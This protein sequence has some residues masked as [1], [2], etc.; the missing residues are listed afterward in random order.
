MSFLLVLAMVIGLMPGMSLTAK[1]QTT[2]SGNGT[3]SDPYRITSADDWNTL[4][5]SV[6]GGIDYSGKYLKLMD[7][8]TVS[9]M[10]GINNHA[11]GSDPQT[12][13]RSF[14]GTFDGDG[15]TLNL[16]IKD[17]NTHGAAP[18]SATKNATIKNLNVT[19]SVVGGI[20]SAG[21]VG[22]PNGTLT[23]E[24]CTVSAAISDSTHHGGFVGH[25]FNATVNLK[26]CIFDGSLTGGTLGGMIGW[27]GLSADKRP[28]IN[29]DNCLFSGTYTTTG[30]FNPVGYTATDNDRATIT[31]FYTTKAASGTATK[32]IINGTINTTVAQVQVGSGFTYYSTINDAVTAWNSAADGAT[33]KLLTDVTTA[34]T[35][36]VTGTKTLDLNDHV[37]TGNV[38]NGSVIEIRNS[39]TLKLVDSATNKTTRY[40][41][42]TSSGSA[43]ISSTGTDQSFTGGYIT[44]TASGTTSNDFN[45]GYHVGGGVYVAKGSTFN[46]NGGNIFGVNHN[47]NNPEGAGVFVCGTFNMNGGEIVGNYNKNNGGGV[48]TSAGSS[49]QISGGT[50]SHNRTSWGGGITVRG[51]FRMSGG[52][53]SGNT[54]SGGGGGIHVD[55]AGNGSPSVTLTGGSITGNTSS[56][57][58]GGI[59]CYGVSTFNISGSPVINGNKHGDAVENVYLQN[60]KKITVNGALTSDASIGITMQTPGVFTAGGNAA[61]YADCFTSDNEIYIVEKEG[62]E[63][64]LA[65]EPHEHDDIDFTVWTS[66]NSL[67]NTA[68]SYYLKN[69]VTISSTWNVPTGTTNLCLNGHVITRNGKGDAIYLDGSDT[70]N[71]YDC[72]TTKRY[73]KINTS[74]HRGEL[75]DS[76]EGADGSFTGGYITASDGRGISTPATENLKSY[77]NMYGGTVFS[78]KSTCGAGIYSFGHFHMYYGAF[79]GNYDSGQSDTWGGAV[80]N[81]G[82]LVIEGG[83]IRHNYDFRGGGVFQ[84]MWKNSTGTIKGGRIVDNIATNNGGGVYLNYNSPTKPKFIICGNPEISG[85]KVGDSENNVYIPDNT[86]QYVSVGGELSNATPIGISMKTPGVFTNSTDVAFNDA[87]KFTSDNE[88]YV[89]IK[90]G[91]NQLELISANTVA[92]VTSGE[93]TTYYDTLKEAISNAPNGS[94]VTLLKDVTETQTAYMN[95]NGTYGGDGNVIDGKTITI[96]SNGIGDER[97]TVTGSRFDVRNDGN[98]TFKNIII[99][100]GVTSS[101]NKV[102]GTTNSWSHYLMAA[103]HGSTLT[104]D[105][106]TLVKNYY[107]SAHGVINAGGGRYGVYNASNNGSTINIKEGSVFQNLGANYGVFRADYKSTINMSGG[108]VTNCTSYQ[109]EGVLAYVAQGSTFNMSGGEISNCSPEGVAPGVVFLHSSQNNGHNTFTMTGGTIE[110]NTAKLGGAVYSDNVDNVITIGGSAAIAS[111]NTGTQIDNGQTGSSNIYLAAGQTMTIDSTHLGGTSNIGVYTKTAPTESADVK[112]A[113]GASK[114]DIQYIHSDLTGNAGTIFCDGEKDWMYY[115]DTLYEITNTHHT[116]AAGT[117]WLTVTASIKAKAVTYNANG[118]SGGN[119]PTDNT[120]YNIGDTVT[121]LGNAG[122]LTRDGY[123]FD[124]WNTKADGSGTTYAAN[125]AFTITEDTTLYAQW[126]KDYAYLDAVWNAT[127]K[128]VDYPEKSIGADKVTV[129][130]ATTTKWNS[131][132][133]AVTENVTISGR[134]TVNGDVKLIL[135]NGAT[136]TATNGISVD[137]GKKFTV[138]GQTNDTNL[139]GILNSRTQT[140]TGVA[141][142]GIGGSGKGKI[143]GVITINGGKVSASGS[144]EAGGAGIGGGFNAS[145]G[146]TVINGGVVTVPTRKSVAGIG[147]GRHGSG[148]NITI[149]G[150]TVNAGGYAGAAIGGAYQGS[151]G[152]ITINGGTVTATDGTRGAAIGSGEKKNSSTNAGTIRINGGKVIAR[153]TA[154]SGSGGAGIGG[155]Y[156][157]PGGTI[158]I[159]GGEVTAT[160]V[161]G[162]GIGGGPGANGG[163]VTI[164]G[165]TVTAYGSSGGVGIGKGKSGKN[166]GSLTIANDH[167]C[168][169][170]D[171]E[172]AAGAC[173]NYQSHRK[174][175]VKIWQHIHSEITYGIEGNVL[176]AACT[177]DTDNCNLVDGKLTLTL[178]APNKLYDAKVYDK[179]KTAWTSVNHNEWEEFSILTGTTSKS[180]GSIEYY[181]GETK[182]GGAPTEEGTYIAKLPIVLNSKNEYLEQEFMIIKPEAIFVTVPEVKELTY[183][184]TGQELITAGVGRDGTIQYSLDDQNYSD[185]IPAATNAGDYTVWVYVKGDDLHNDSPKVSFDVTIKKKPA[186]ILTDGQ[187]PTANTAVPEGDDPDK[188]TPLLNPP[189]EAAPDGYKIVYAIGKD[190][191]NVPETGWSEDIPEGKDGTYYIW[192]KAVKDDNHEETKP[193]N[194]KVTR[195]DYNVTLSPSTPTVGEPVTVAVTPKDD[196]VVY[197]W[198]TG[199]DSGE[200]TLIAGETGNTYTPTDADKGRTLKV[201]AKLGDKVIGEDIAD[202]PVAETASETDKQIVEGEI[203]ESDGTTKVVNAK[204]TLKRGNTVVAT[205]NTDDNGKYSFS[206]ES[207][208][209]NVVSEYNGVTKTEL[210]EITSSQDFDLTMPEKNTN[211]VLVVGNDAPDIMVGGL[212]VEAETVRA[213]QNG[214]P[215]TVTVTMTVEKKE[216]STETSENINA[217]KQQASDKTLEFFETKLVKVVDNTT[218]NAVTETDNVLTIVVPYDFTGKDNVTVYRSYGETTEALSDKMPGTDGTFQID[219][220]AKTI[221]I[222]TSRLATYAIGYNA[223]NKE[224][225]ETFN[226]EK[227]EQKTAADNLIKEDDSDES[228]DL[229]EAA[230]K[231]I[232]ELPYDYDK[233]LDK[234]KEALDEIINKLEKDL[235]K[236]RVL[237]KL[238]DTPADVKIDQGEPVINVDT[239]KIPEE[240]VEVVEEIAKKTTADIEDAVIKQAQEIVNKSDDVEDSDKNIVIIPSLE[241]DAK[242]YVLSEDDAKLTLDIEAVYKSYETTDDINNAADTMS[243]AASDDEADREKVREIGKGTIDTKGTPVNIRIELPEE[244]AQSIGAT[245]DSTNDAPETAYVKHSSNGINYEYNAKIYYD[246]DG[247]VA[248]FVDPNGLGTFTLSGNSES[249]VSTGGNN[250]TDLQSAIDDTEDGAVIKL[251]NDENVSATINEEKTIT[252]DKDDH[253]G[254][255]DITVPP[256]LILTK[257]DNEDG[258]TTYKAVTKYTVTFNANGGTGTMAVQEIGGKAALNANTFTREGFVFDGWNTKADGKGT[259]YADKADITPTA[260]M[261]LYAQWKENPK[262]EDKKEDDK[263][264]DDKKAD[265]PKTDDKKADE[266]KIDETLEASKKNAEDKINNVV[267]EVNKIVDSLTN[268]TAEKKEELKKQNDTTIA[269][270]KNAVDS[271]IYVEAVEAAYQKAIEATKATLKDAIKTEVESQIVAAKKTIDN[272]KGLTNNQKKALKTEVDKEAK[273]VID[274]L[275]ST[276][277]KIVDNAAKGTTLDAA[278]TKENT[279][280]V[281]KLMNKTA[282]IAKE[283]KSDAQVEVAANKYATPE[284]LRKNTLSIN[285]KLKVEQVGKKIIIEWGK[286]KDADGY[287]VFVQYCGKDFSKKASK[288]IKKNSTTKLSVTKINGKKLN[289]KKNYKILVRAYK[290]AGGKKLNIGKSITAHIVGLKNNN[291]TNVKDIKITNHTIIYVGVGGTHKIKAKTILV[292]SSKKQLS[293]AHAKEFRYASADPEIAKVNAKGEVTGI[294]EGSTIIYVYARNGYTKEIKLIVVK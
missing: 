211:S 209:Y 120:P 41:T 187:K 110:G 48:G 6:N 288:T 248:E 149:N 275:D 9:Q 163:K 291:Y 39:A 8:I 1:A 136:L 245:E 12:N 239:E 78:C 43:T 253:T 70:L 4:A 108:L 146:T 125:A 75:V 177:D 72:G 98:L 259:A 145:G 238:T 91:S 85:N 241:I 192:F 220:E 62:D 59:N 277:E 199:D 203:Y 127:T 16:N 189:T 144:R 228:K 95:N 92:S 188:E 126:M 226:T 109:N 103:S 242:D 133:Y 119:V 83:L 176:T 258:T 251:I 132:W 122:S 270:A 246:D 154:G 218:D 148:G 279:A 225:V 42:P 29:I 292:D 216:D 99:D 181:Q 174:K 128:Q 44:G 28:S 111:G 252:I 243:A 229:V 197:E 184:G 278:S 89:V 290:K 200:F 180:G 7:D 162:A 212:D 208:I 168:L 159:T 262:T 268:I 210:V 219:N 231:A 56:Q 179:A 273:K 68:G 60:P 161:Y 173:F 171:S 293:D 13:R 135:C 25:A 287:Q 116:H 206:V 69:D 282:E 73:Y 190:D 106:G 123:T 276:V 52:T 37:L 45:S 5:T 63:L 233:T 57:N 285:M 269:D 47:G 90:N 22:V 104:F 158:I 156:N 142:A 140:T 18:F 280:L 271:S 79:I 223:I 74:T 255:V 153:N 117:I 87:G 265:E 38:S 143:S 250:Y 58:G 15:H 194:I 286:V 19:G 23:V 201:V 182:L 172:S 88:S 235:E 224:S 193:E 46:M 165:G 152:N 207:G 49:V 36:N 26:S 65:T 84:E 150:G 54:A 55:N 96:T 50:I 186:P 202:L 34:S 261:T 222:Y 274:S 93:T 121:V 134:V 254:V 237:D 124:G 240:Y 53:I 244:F 267:A 205:T 21:L 249:V 94:T 260:D 101:A 137:S 112:I 232:D 17:K 131:G 247:Y 51:T 230:K 215:G 147:G 61:Q 100:G 196:T 77:V 118:A 64:K 97:K 113:S 281:N 227:E 195:I 263:S 66:N 155:G 2:L 294:K 164:S 284:K 14:S 3:E 102:N 40:Y 32:L 175:W 234:N 185:E 272:T 10:I 217:I 266:P 129:V 20:H 170:G 35:I 178:T 82:E 213:A 183:D 256:T 30:A 157:V 214:E 27:S 130:N 86:S 67:P 139:M 76:E 114:D 105:T 138:Y 191:T 221:T 81:A 24:N 80:Y 141:S 107:A 283:A 33:L 204:I 198:Y 31:N 115:N 257:T 289:L 236:Q 160:S 11:S 264:K 71:I 167:V 166:Q 169:A 151:A